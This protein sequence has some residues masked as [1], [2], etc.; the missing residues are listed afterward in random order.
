LALT[1][2]VKVEGLPGETIL[3]RYLSSLEVVYVAEPRWARGRLM[4]VLA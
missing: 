3:Y 1:K 2:G 4:F